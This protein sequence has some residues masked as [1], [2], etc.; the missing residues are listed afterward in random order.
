MVRGRGCQSRSYRT[1]GAIARRV[2]HVGPGITQEAL[3]A[4]PSL[5]LL[6]PVCT[7][8]I[9]EHLSLS[10]VLRV[11]LLSAVCGISSL[12]RTVRLRL[13]REA[14]YTTARELLIQQREQFHRSNIN[15]INTHAAFPDRTSPEE[16]VLVQVKQLP[17]SHYSQHWALNA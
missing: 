7:T 9:H 11:S 4:H 8:P 6:S 15:H 16:L 13:D 14:S 12:P 17:A 5:A 3:L 10:G 2:L 1:A